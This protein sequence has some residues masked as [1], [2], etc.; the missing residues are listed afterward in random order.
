MG[1]KESDS[2]ATT[3]R[4]KTGKYGV[5]RMKLSREGYRQKVKAFLELSDRCRDP[6]RRK[7]LM[8]MAYVYRYEMKKAYPKA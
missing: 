7:V 5:R 3:R 4:P 2:M 8:Q 1:V 6:K